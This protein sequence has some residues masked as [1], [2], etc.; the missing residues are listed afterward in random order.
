MTSVGARVGAE[1]MIR[2]TLYAVSRRRAAESQ[3]P[4]ADCD[5]LQA[6]DSKIK[7]AQLL[8]MFPGPE[9]TVTVR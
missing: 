7:N 9:I 2:R 8:C 5:I 1:T 6:I 4:P 3:L